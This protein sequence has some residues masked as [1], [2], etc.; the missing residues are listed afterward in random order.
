MPAQNVIGMEQAPSRV[1]ADGIYSL[2]KV[3]A[4][5][6]GDIKKT[7]V[8]CTIGPACSTPEK[9]GQML[10]AGMDV[11]RLNFSH[12]THDSHKVMLTT[13][14]EAFRLNK[15]KTCAVMLD[16][17]GP[18]IRT[19]LLNSPKVLLVKDQVIEISTDYTLKGDCTKITCS[20]EELPNS[21]KVGQHILIAD[22]S[23]VIKVTEILEKGVRGI[24]LNDAE[25]T[26]KKNMNLPGCEV[27]LP[28]ITEKDKDDIVN[29]GVKNGVDMIA[30]SFTRTAKDVEDCRDLL[31]PKGAHIKI[32][33]KIE[34]QEGLHNYDE[35]LSVADGIMVARGDLGMEIPPEKVFIAQKWMIEKARAVGKPIIVATQ[36]LE[37]MIKNPRPT[38]AE[39][40][41]VANAVIEGADCVMLSG[42]SA[43]GSYP[44]QAVMTMVNV[45]REAEGCLNYKKLFEET[46][47][48]DRLN[49]KYFEQDAMCLSAV[50]LSL[51]LQST[52]IVC[53]TETGLIP[54]LLSKYRPNCHIVAVSIDEKVMRGLTVNYGVVSLKVP[55]FQGTDLIIPYAIK[56]AVEKGIVK[57]NDMIVVMQGVNEEAP[58][59][60]NIVKVVKAY[61]HE[62]SFHKPT[63]IASAD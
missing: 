35:I 48:N 29:F 11:A 55:S 13:L 22:G 57:V 18:E 2:A 44:L 12:G 19:G 61:I 59:Q 51:K 30:L 7:K 32:I 42:E 3:L 28:T 43:N 37:S 52:A 49:P 8:V 38:R 53:F 63:P 31:G 25:L 62:G 56:S 26:E 6:R 45:C 58:D 9:L 34:N 14:R 27:K 46:L 17:K 10:E 54:R 47:H 16:T 24:C 5:S 1:G 20:Y 41:D 15:G 60:E 23:L 33:C 4:P 39:A 21:V 50:L 36:M 40:G